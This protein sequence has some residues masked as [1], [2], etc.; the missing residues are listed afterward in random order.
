VKILRRNWT[1]FRFFID[2]QVETTYL[3]LIIDILDEEMNIHQHIQHDDLTTIWVVNATDNGFE[4]LESESRQAFEE[5]VMQFIL[6]EALGESA[7][8]HAENGAPFLPNRPELNVS[9]S[10]SD[11][12]FALCVSKLKAVG[13]DIEAHG[14]ILQKVENYFLSN[15]ELA[16]FQPTELDLCVLWGA[17]ESVFK[18]LRGELTNL[19]EDIE[20]VSMDEHRVVAECLDQSFQL[21]H[22][23][24]DFYTL[25]YLLEADTFAPGQ[26]AVAS[27][28]QCV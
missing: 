12:W 2:R 5:R 26:S 24:N 19:K 9:I 8:E 14:T 25:V 3:V 27:D 23:R 4:K 16:R 28:E 17:K 11:T 13:I 10:H 20:I 7:L 22:A 18:S 21:K 15:A 1:F 6:T